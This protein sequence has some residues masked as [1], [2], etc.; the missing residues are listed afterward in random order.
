M[1]KLLLSLFAISGLFLLTG[2]S[3]NSKATPEQNTTD[4]DT[5]IEEFGKMLMDFKGN[6]NN[7]VD[8]TEE[9]IDNSDTDTTDSED[10]KN[11]LEDFKET[12]NEINTNGDEKTMQELV[13]DAIDDFD[14][15]V[16]GLLEDDMN[17]PKNSI[18]D[19]AMEKA[20]KDQLDEELAKKDFEKMQD[21]EAKELNKIIKEEEEAK[22]IQEMRKEAEAKM[23]ERENLN[24]ILEEIRRSILEDYNDTLNQ[25]FREMAEKKN[26]KTT[27]FTCEDACQMYSDC[28][29]YGEGVDEKGMREAYKSCLQ[30]CPDRSHEALNCI[31]KIGKINSAIDCA[32]LTMC[33][34]QKTDFNTKY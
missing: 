25:K 11:F 34:L 1:K 16:D 27:T 4:N 8:A 3:L 33:V 29:W 9:Q 6:V 13:Q 18:E 21:E 31:K 15:W 14:Q 20:F 17:P 28:A 23:I 12:I 5:S 10:V 19:D 26:K 30:I 22:Q 7:K 2:C 24:E 32:P